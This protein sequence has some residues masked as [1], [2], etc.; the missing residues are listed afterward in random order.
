MQNTGPENFTETPF[1][2][3]FSTL[4]DPRRTDKGNLL[5]SL[6]EILFLTISAAVSGANTWTGV[7]S[8]GKM[9]ITWLREFFEYKNGIPSHDAI[10][11]LFCILDPVGFE[12]CFVNWINNIS[13]ICD[14]E[15]VA[16]D[17]KTVRGAASSAPNKKYPLHIVSAYAAKSR[18]CLGQ[19]A[20]DEKSNEIT[21]IPKLLQA[22]AINGCIVTIDAMGCQ[23]DIASAI[24]EKQADYILMVKDNQE[25]LKEQI[26]KVFKLTADINSD[27]DIDSGH[28]RVETRTCSATQDLKFLDVKNDWKN[29]R[30]I[31]KIKSERCLKQTGATSDEVRY[32]ISSLLPDAKKLN[33]SIRRHWS[34]ENNL[35]W[36][37]DVIFKEDGQLKRK[38]NSAKN[39]NI[40]SKIALGMLEKEESIKNSKNNKRLMAALD[41]K[42]RLKILKC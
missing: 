6:E 35:H 34:I 25:E 17:G 1:H 38:G 26:E 24:V 23:K 10:S 42:Y 27:I 22:L 29:L 39:F 15:V 5:Y 11:D 31:I 18:L 14:G 33:E 20:T 32:Y 19:Y 41:D 16:V 4:E 2:Q 12:S 36:S 3:S 13:D 37:L 40:I 9:K 28:G 7:E 30:S 21:A 8:F